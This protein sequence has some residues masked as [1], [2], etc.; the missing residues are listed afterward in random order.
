M[1]DM[2][3]P[4]PA[5]EYPPAPGTTAAPAAAQ[6]TAATAVRLALYAGWTMALLYG[7]IEPP[8]ESPWELPTVH[9]LPEG[10]RRELELLRLGSLLARLARLPEC[11]GSGLP[12][13]VPGIDDS[14]PYSPALAAFNQEIL[15]ALATAAPELQRAYE[16]GRSLRDTVN[17]PRDPKAATPPP[18]AL[19]GQLSHWRVSTLQEWLVTLAAE[20]PQYTGA[21]VAA[22]L[23]RWSDFAAVTLGTPAAPT[24]AGAQPAGTGTQTTG[25]VKQA[26]TGRQG[27]LTKPGRLR[28]ETQT[29]LAERM[30]DYLLPQGDVWLMLL[31]GARS[32]DGLLTPEGYVA[33]GEAALRRSARIVRRVIQHY[34]P[35]LAIIAAALGGLLFLAITSLGGAA[36][37]W[38]TIATVAGSLGIS[39]RTIMS[40]V[41]RL[42][43]E[44]EKPVLTAAE[45]DAMAWAI[46]TLPRVS[47]NTRGVRQLRRAGI[48]PTSALG[49]V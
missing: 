22:S 24:G 20:F 16:L 47:L 9:E 44:A 26:G 21:I 1:T 15:D 38:T 23:G 4:T 49:R 34:W 35:V 37:V 46:T 48:A 6:E 5:A 32:T 28:G 13:Q 43:S 7:V 17:P 31:T 2:H 41:A 30:Y 25:A 39:A 12:T 10:Q 45:E 8:A 36:K 40:T 27:W 14:A 29:D 19:A 3:V 33:A 18:D 42:A 11:D